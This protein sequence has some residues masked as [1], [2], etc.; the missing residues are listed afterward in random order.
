LNLIQ[1]SLNAG[2]PQLKDECRFVTTQ[3]DLILKVSTRWV[4]INLTQLKL[5]PT[6]LDL[7]FG[8]LNLTKIHIN[9]TQLRLKPTQLNLDLN[10]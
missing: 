4:L 1:L 10:W 3:L 8:Q 5:G 9:S 2:W 7:G 6:R